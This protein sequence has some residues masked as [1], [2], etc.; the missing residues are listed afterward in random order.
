[1]GTEFLS[2]WEL[3]VLMK[4]LGHELSDEDQRGISSDG[5]RCVS[6]GDFLGIMARREQD[7]AQRDKLMQA[8]SV[9]DCDGSGFI[10]VDLQSEFRTRMMSLGPN[11]YTKE[12]FELFMSE[13][14]AE[15]PNSLG[16]QHPA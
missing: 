12:E 5:E 7:L 2:K 15:A 9:F 10:S 16:T 14:L 4:S 3:G 6:L 11:P 8:F 13:S 1:M